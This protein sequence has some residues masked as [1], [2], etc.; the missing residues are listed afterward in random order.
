MSISKFN[1]DNN[2]VAVGTQNGFAIYTLDPIELRYK[3]ASEGIGV[4]EMLYCTSLVALVGSGHT[5]GSSPRKLK[6]LN[7]QTKE[8]ICEL[9][10][11]STIMDIKLCRQRMIICL[12]D[13]IHIYDLNTIKCIQILSATATSNG[14]IAYAPEPVSYLAFPTTFGTPSSG[15]VTAV[16]TAGS[17]SSGS[18]KGGPGSAYASVLAPTN[19]CGGV[20]IYDTI[21]L[22]LITQINAHRNGIAA[23]EFSADG[24][25][26]ATASSSGTM[27]RVFGLPT[28]QHIYSFRRGATHATINSLSFDS[29]SQYLLAGTSTGN[30]TIHIF[31]LAQAA[32]GTSGSSMTAKPHAPLASG[33]T[34]GSPAALTAASVLNTVT[35]TAYVALT[36]VTLWSKAVA[37]GM[38]VLPEPVSEFANSYRAC[39]TIKL[40]ES[41][42]GGT[43][44]GAGAGSGGS[45]CAYTAAFIRC[46]AV[47]TDSNSKGTSSEAPVA[48]DDCSQSAMINKIAVVTEEGHMYRYVMP[49]MNTD[50]TSSSV[51]EQTSEGH[52]ETSRGSLGSAD[53]LG[54]GAAHASVCVLEDEALLC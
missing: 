22:R 48:S 25:L 37:E 8:N 32:A 36:N 2:C 14:L 38:G 42:G 34:G 7:L 51:E 11:P 17:T 30:G 3:D 12:Q 18:T 9:N 35:S 43:G 19:A 50:A 39:A 16:G 29:S 27:V 23:M 45:R 46:P 15:A 52:L 49:T 41:G 40:P 1:Q 5:P 53:G 31:S 33:T 44:S 10:F 54:A 4:I 26:L 47:S 24:K 20:L 6:L 28:G 21:S 13:Q